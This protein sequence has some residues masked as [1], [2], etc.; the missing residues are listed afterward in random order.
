MFLVINRPCVLLMWAAALAPMLLAAPAVLAAE[1]D[2]EACGRDMRDAADAELTIAACSNVI[3]RGEAESAERRAWAYLSRGNAKE[4]KGDHDGALADYDATLRLNPKET[5]AHSGR[6]M[7]YSRLGDQD[8][9]IAELD[10]AIELD[11]SFAVL[12]DARASAYGIKG[13]YE[14][15]ITDYDQALRIEP[16]NPFIHNNR[17]VAYEHKGSLVPAILDYRRALALEPDYAQ[18]RKNLTR[19]LRAILPAAPKP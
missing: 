8:R 6:G 10:I 5:L 11:Q 9:A 16:E 7:I 14:R 15:A 1:E 18:A 13:D 4:L 2:A 17:G 3:A 12:Y 19:A